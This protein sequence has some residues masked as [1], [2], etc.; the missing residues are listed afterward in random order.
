LIKIQYIKIKKKFKDNKPPDD[1]VH[2]SPGNQG[3]QT[4]HQRDGRHYSKVEEI[5]FGGV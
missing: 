4:I 2:N 1:P 3:T 5:D